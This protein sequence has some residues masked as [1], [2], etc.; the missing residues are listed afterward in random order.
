M[1]M[2]GKK[3]E[4][5]LM[6]AATAE[7]KVKFL[8]RSMRDLSEELLEKKSILA[9]LTRSA[10]LEESTSGDGAVAELVAAA[11]SG[12]DALA[13]LKSMLARQL[14]ENGRMKRDMK[15]LATD[16][17]SARDRIDELESTVGAV[18][19]PAGMADGGEADGHVG[20]DVDGEGDGAA[21]EGAGGDGAGGAE[22][23][24]GGGEGT[25]G[26]DGGG[27]DGLA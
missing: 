27:A 15:L 8:E 11:A 25:G 17:M 10:A 2:M 24:G 7:E 18:V 23:A 4:A 3:V 20:D 26:E 16:L 12:P 22:G 6:R 21:G 9:Q 13:T 1:E 19:A 14:D 5:A